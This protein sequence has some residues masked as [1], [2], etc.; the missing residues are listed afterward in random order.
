M[1]YIIGICGGSASGKTAFVQEIRER[2]LDSEVCLLSMDN[3]YKSIDR[4]P[5][6]G[7]GVANFDSPESIDIDKLLIDLRGLKEGNTIHGWEYA[8]NNPDKK[9]VAYTLTGAPVIIV[10]GIFVL[11][12]DALLKELDLRLF[13]DAKDHI[14]LKRRIKRDWEERGYT[15]EDVFY[16]Y[17]H[18]VVPM[19]ERFIEPT[20]YIADIIISNNV[21]FSTGLEVISA[22]IRDILGKKAR[23]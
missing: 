20:K 3:Y 5:V 10:E 15:M 22:H 4:Q 6:D 16:R 12:F 8:F 11:V 2:F 18:H 19:Y 14:R 21:S 13:V 9:P 1:P 23:D 17:E 7:A